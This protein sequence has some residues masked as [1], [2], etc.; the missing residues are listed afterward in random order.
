MNDKHRPWASGLRS[1]ILLKLAAHG[2]QTTHEL[3]NA[4]QVSQTALA[5]R[6]SELEALGQVRD[7]GHRR[8]SVSGRGRPLKVWA[9]VDRGADQIGGEP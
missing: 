6:L 1:L 5:P 3:A 4:C 2:P 9:A 7:T 8:R